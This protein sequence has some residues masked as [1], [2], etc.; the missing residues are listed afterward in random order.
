[1]VITWRI[2]LGMK[3]FYFIMATEDVCTKD[4]CNTVTYV[5]DSNEI[6]LN[7]GKVYSRIE[8]PHILSSERY[9]ELI[10][11]E[12]TLTIEW[13]RYATLHIERKTI[14][15]A[16]CHVISWEPLSKDF[17][18]LDCI[19]LSGAFWYGGSELHAQRWPLSDT[20]LKM[21]EFVSEDVVVKWSSFGN[22]LEP[23]WIN[24]NGVAVYVNTSVPL[25]V[26]FNES[27][28]GKMCF[29]SQ[30]SD[31]YPQNSENIFPSLKYMICKGENIQSIFKILRPVLMDK[32]KDM[33]D[34]RMMKSPIW[35]TWAKYKVNIDQ[36]KVLK[37]ADEIVD[38]GF[39]NSQLE[40]DDM[41][42]T[43]YGDFDFD[44]RKFDDPINMV[45][46][47]KAKGFRT[48]VWVTPFANLDSKAFEEGLQKG[49]WLQ[50]KSRNVPMLVKWWQG[51]G[52][53]LDVTNPEAISWYNGRLNSMKVEYGIDSFKFD[54][55][56]RTF[57]PPVFSSFKAMNSS[58]DYM[59][60][61]VEM[62]S[63][64]GT[65][66]EVRCGYRSQ[67]HPVF[68]RMADKESRWGYNNGL[69]T[70]IPTAL[71]FGILGYPFILPDMIGGNGYGEVLVQDIVM[72]SRELYIRWLQVTA[73]LPAMQF[74]FAPWD[75]D[76]KV[77]EIARKMVLVHENEVSP[78]L[79]EASKQAVSYGKFEGRQYTT[80]M[81]VIIRFAKTFVS[82]LCNTHT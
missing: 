76:A 73:Y 4:S 63:A 44:P 25:Y 5:S 56:E 58:N 49:Y 46:Q 36:E 6:L 66:I 48:T 29:K 61:Y 33:P 45:K 39:T 75:Y 31:S 68:V 26:S 11:S 2:L 78:I 24:S 51:V 82:F 50:D 72:P 59:T 62:V 16:Q 69:K 57:L 14:N 52:A 81:A 55:G 60:K 17:V 20:N 27:N 77:V 38:H 34:I 71:T 1:M 70:L 10:S 53:I 7:E 8:L 64:H 3:I 15:S 41:Y 19:S 67:E 40:I 21:Q 79:I 35:S 22:V 28:S 43:K 54:A 37:Y 74:S 32:P 23:F 47:L 12:E 42:T 9:N 30:F 65:M 13:H 18:P 80:L